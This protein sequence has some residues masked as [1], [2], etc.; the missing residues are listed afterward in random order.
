[1]PNAFY[2]QELEVDLAEGGRMTLP[3]RYP[4]L[5]WLSVRAVPPGGAVRVRRGRGPEV[6]L[7]ETAI[8]R[9]PLA[10]GEYTVILVH[11]G[12]GA[13]TTRTVQVRPGET[14]EVRVGSNEW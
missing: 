14:A 10:A 2:E 9:R 6:S 4:S 1:D 13:R 3:V 7:G 12:T 11:P 8:A 5:G